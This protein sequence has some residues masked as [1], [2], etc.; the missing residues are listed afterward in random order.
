[1]QWT[2]ATIVQGKLKSLKNSDSKKAKT[3]APTAASSAEVLVPCLNGKAA[4]IVRPSLSQIADFDPVEHVRIPEPVARVEAIDVRNLMQRMVL[5]QQ[6]A[7]QGQL[8]LH[9]NL[10]EQFV[11]MLPEVLPGTV[12]ADPRSYVVPAPVLVPCQSSTTC[13]PTML[14]CPGLTPDQWEQSVLQPPVQEAQNW[15]KAPVSIILK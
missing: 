3:E 14:Y 5:F 2:R 6:E 1:M 8:Q 10:F 13:P 15:M 11:R 9:Q 7:V 12:G 4:V